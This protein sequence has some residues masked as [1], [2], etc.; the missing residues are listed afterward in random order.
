MVASMKINVDWCAYPHEFGEITGEEFLILDPIP[1]LKYYSDNKDAS[2][3][4]CPAY[5]NYYKNTFV[6]CSPIDI[7]IEINKDH[8]WANVIV[9]KDLPQIMFNPRFKEENNSLYPVF[10]L[11]VSKLLMTTKHP[12]VYIEQ[13]EP[14]LEWERATDIRIISGNFNIS[15][16]TRPLE[17][18]FEQ[19]NKN[20]VV[21]FKRGQP[22]YYVRFITQD[23]DDIVI[24]NKTEITKELYDD[25][26]RCVSIKG[27]KPNTALNVLY[28]LRD[29]FLGK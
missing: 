14:L 16:W 2:F 11:R 19:R 7:E 8:N 20:I 13:S 4:K 25:A 18:A 1:V 22:M 23:P 5:L 24:L 10:S 15:K 28:S 3:Q 17:A 27:F 29:K 21:K 6:V 9:P 26:L 12:N